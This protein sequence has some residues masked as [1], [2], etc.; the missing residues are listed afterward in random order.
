VVEQPAGRQGGAE[1]VD[2]ALAHLQAPGQFGHAE[3]PVGGA[4]AVEHPEGVRDRGEHFL[5]HRSAIRDTG[6]VC[7]M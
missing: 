2:G 7:G 4:E 6:L 3:F 1:A 5:R